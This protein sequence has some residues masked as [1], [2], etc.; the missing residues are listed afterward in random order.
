MLDREFVEEKLFEVSD[1]T[2][3]IIICGV[4]NDTRSEW[5]M[6]FALAILDIEAKEVNES[7]LSHVFI[8][9]TALKTMLK[10]ED[11]FELVFPTVERKQSSSSVLAAQSNEISSTHSRKSL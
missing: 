2:A 8:F 5:D 7:E 4:I 6:L 9:S 10:A 1:S 3:P 11:P